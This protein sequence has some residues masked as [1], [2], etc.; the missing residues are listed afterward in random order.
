MA[1]EELC[2]LQD[3]GGSLRG[4][5][6]DLDPMASRGRRR[7]RYAAGAPVR[8]NILLQ[9]SIPVT[10]YLE[11]S[12]LDFGQTAANTVPTPGA[13]EQPFHGG[14]DLPAPPA[15]G[16]SLPFPMSHGTTTLAFV[17]QGGVL[18][19]ADTRSSCSGLVACPSSQKIIPVHSHLVGTTS[20]TSADCALWK[21]LLARELRLYQLR[22]GRR[23]STGGAA[24][25]LSHMLRPFKGTELCVAATLCGWDGGEVVRPGR[26]QRGG[27]ADAAEMNRP[28]D[29]P[30]GCRSG[31]RLYYVCSDGTRLQG[32]LFSVGSGSPYAYSVLDSE[33]R[34]GLSVEEATVAA[35]EAVYRATH[36]DAYS[37]NCVD[38]YHVDSRGWT[39]RCREDLKDEYYR[40]KERLK[41]N[42]KKRREEEEVN[43]VSTKT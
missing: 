12:P 7:S 18:A 3:L 9:F 19:A 20:G 37:G 2:G 16:V 27:P 11:K 32:E 5:T 38:V 23:L 26:C 33:V 21:R 14:V 42:V 29:T 24:K 41:A 34:W 17:F 8:N 15:G 36:R 13:S 39:R 10:Q 40:E 25:L 1:L 43:L 4:L 31:P 22:H 35:R 6:A 30:T 28:G